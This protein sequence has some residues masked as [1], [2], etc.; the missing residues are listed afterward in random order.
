MKTEIVITNPDIWGYAGE[1]DG[2]PYWVIKSF[3]WDGDNCTKE[4]SVKAQFFLGEMELITYMMQPDGSAIS[5]T[6]EE[7][8]LFVIS[9]HSE[10]AKSMHDALYHDLRAL[11]S[12]GEFYTQ[13][14]YPSIIS[15]LNN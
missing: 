13:K 4:V 12:G 9:D 10:K 1:I 7:F 11:A 3:V 14:R 8:E 5:I 6:C 15:D 2:N